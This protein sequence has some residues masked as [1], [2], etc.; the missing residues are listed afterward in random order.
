LIKLGWESIRARSFILFHLHYRIF[1]LHFGE[2]GAQLN[3]FF[4]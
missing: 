4:R 2:V 1:H 3:F